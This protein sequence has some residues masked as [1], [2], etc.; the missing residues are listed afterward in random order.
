MTAPSLRAAFA[1]AVLESWAPACAGLDVGAEQLG[2]IMLRAHQREAVRR[3][4]TLIA[5]F[6]GALL[7]D[8]VGLGKTFVALAV[9]RSLGGA[10]V[11]APATLREEW[12]RAAGQAGTAPLP[13]TSFESLSRG[14]MP[15]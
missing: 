10:H 2:D 12:A 6:G 9:A 3:C 5:H 13:F 14:A 11:V 15:A 1:R 4:T 8:Q 7:A